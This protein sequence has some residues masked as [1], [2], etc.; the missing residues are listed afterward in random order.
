MGQ[1]RYLEEP[2]QEASDKKRVAIACQGGG[3]HMAFT[4]GVI[5]W[6]LLSGCPRSDELLGLSGTPGGAAT[7][8]ATR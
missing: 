7:P 5:E 8:V 6:L 2:V 4:A 3:S 1:P